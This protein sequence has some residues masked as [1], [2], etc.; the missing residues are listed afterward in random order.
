M[1]ARQT[2]RT[3]FDL[4][5]GGALGAY[6]AGATC[7]LEARG[8]RPDMVAGI[9]IS[10]QDIPRY[11]DQLEV[12]FD[13]TFDPA[14]GKWMMERKPGEPDIPGASS[15]RSPG[16]PDGHG[17]GRA[18]SSLHPAYLDLHLRFFAARPFW[19]RPT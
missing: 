15:G 17:A 8:I 18:L 4:Q 13:A 16:D 10:S 12:P 3:A 11:L 5:G 1:R 2:G 9:S 19:C 7:A 6:Q 14:L